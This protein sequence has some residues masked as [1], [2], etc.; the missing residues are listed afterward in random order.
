M[1]RRE[2]EMRHEI[3]VRNMMWGSDYPHPEG[4]WP[5]TRQQQVDSLHGI[6]DHELEA[7]LGGNAVEFY[8]LDAEKLAP[9]SARIGPEKGSFQEETA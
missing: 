6:P 8:G 4:S 5:V 2:A 7:I 9:I 1:S 3:G